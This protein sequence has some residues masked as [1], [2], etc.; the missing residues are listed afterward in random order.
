V[1]AIDTNV[2]VYAEI[3][4]STHHRTARRLLVGLAEGQAPWAIPWPCVYE[5]LRVVTHPRVF[6]PP[7]P[8]E[9]AMRDLAQILASPSLILLSETDRHAE[10]MNSVVDAS[11]VTGNLI[12][13]AHIAALCI[14]HG[15]SELVTG[16]RDF[17]RFP[18]RVRNP[19]V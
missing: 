13:D 11:A 1:W 9:L 3:V 17:S 10:V 18:I 15:V 7:V 16:D 12:H 19:F 4:T 6:T 2:L 8:I 5:F 14:E